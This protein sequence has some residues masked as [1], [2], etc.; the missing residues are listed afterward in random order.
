MTKKINTCLLRGHSDIMQHFKQRNLKTSIPLLLV[1][2]P[3]IVGSN[4][5]GHFISG[6]EPFGSH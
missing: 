4:H 1:N 3:E 5:F 2:S 6:E